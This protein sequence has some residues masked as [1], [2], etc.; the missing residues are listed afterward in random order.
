MPET[1]PYMLGSIYQELTNDAGGPRT[2]GEA[3]IDAR[4][5]EGST[6]W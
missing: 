5:S 4:V 3:Q 1:K 2:F 6:C